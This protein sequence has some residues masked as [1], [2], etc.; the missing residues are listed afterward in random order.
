MG[1]ALALLPSAE[2]DVLLSD[3]GLPDGTG[4]DLL[5]EA[6]QV[7]GI[8]LYAVAMSGYGD[9][10]DRERSKRAGF[11]HHLVKPFQKAELEAALDAA[12]LRV[13][14]GGERPCL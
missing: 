10:V 14:R 7:M 3:L 6:N 1:S 13:P 2:F 8:P 9:S 5:T 4:W 11:H 12:T